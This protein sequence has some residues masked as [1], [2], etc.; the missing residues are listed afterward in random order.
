MHLIFYTCFREKDEMIEQKCHQ[1]KSI[2]LLEEEIK[3]FN[4]HK[5]E[6]EDNV[7]NIMT[8]FEVSKNKL[9]KMV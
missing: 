4:L 6:I 3:I 1:S 5:N 2:Q 8:N 9:T 7:A